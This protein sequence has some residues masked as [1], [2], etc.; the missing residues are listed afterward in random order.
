MEN[1]T[2]FIE[3]PTAGW[4]FGYGWEVLKKHFVNKLRKKK[5]Q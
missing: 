1:N 5:L 4:A 2:A 3:K